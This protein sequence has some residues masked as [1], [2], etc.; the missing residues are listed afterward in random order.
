MTRDNSY[1]AVLARKP[2]IIRNA[3]GATIPSRERLH[4]V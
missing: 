3:V 4:R 1:S 2:E